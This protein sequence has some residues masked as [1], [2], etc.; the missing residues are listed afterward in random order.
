MHMMADRKG[1]VHAVLWRAESSPMPPDL[2]T[3][4]ARQGVRWEEATGALDAFSSVLA[5]RRSS[6]DSRVLLLVEPLSL[7]G[8]DEVRGALDRFDPAARCWSFSEAAK[9]RLSPLGPLPRVAEPEVVVRKPAASVGGP[10]LRLAGLGDGRKT[11]HM[12]T[13]QNGAED[14]GGDPPEEAR[15]PRSLLTPEELDMLLADDR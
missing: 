11:E 2:V 14:G 3:A 9:P 15:P 8:A 7:A 13:L 5:A 12:P 10:A 4:L 1:N 6:P